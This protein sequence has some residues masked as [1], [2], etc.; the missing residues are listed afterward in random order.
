MALEKDTKEWQMF[1]DYFKLCKHFWDIKDTGQYWEELIDAT[2]DFYNRYKDIPL[3]KAMI[4]AFSE[5]QDKLA[6]EKTK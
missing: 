2:N 5:T 6:R 3:A 1:G 4:I